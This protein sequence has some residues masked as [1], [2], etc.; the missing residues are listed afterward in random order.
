MKTLLEVGDLAPDFSLVGTDGLI[1][2]M[3]QFKGYRASVVFF[4]CNL[5]PF[6]RG[7]DEYL[8]DLAETF[9]KKGV[10]FL[11]INPNDEGS[12]TAEQMTALMEEF[13][14]PWKYLQDPTQQIAKRFGAKATPHIF[15]FDHHRTLVYSGRA[16]DDPR[17]PAS[18][19]TED[20]KDA[21]IELLDLRPITNSETAPIGCTIKWK[22]APIE[23]ETELLLV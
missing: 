5:C 3:N 6:A 23:A 11:G 1:Y 13:K 16:I 14:F 19:S 10:L 9:Y 20:L 17:N 15:L 8:R 18:A 2:G 7:M 22:V 4:T 12:D 21:L